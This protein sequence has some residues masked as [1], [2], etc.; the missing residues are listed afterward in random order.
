MINF[1]INIL[2]YN[3]EFPPNVIDDLTFNNRV[4]CCVVFIREPWQQVEASC[5]GFRKI[6]DLKIPTNRK[7]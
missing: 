3:R 7:R 1:K 6:S 5:K 4:A 2:I